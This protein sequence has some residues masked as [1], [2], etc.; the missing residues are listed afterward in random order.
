MGRAALAPWLLGCGLRGAP[1]AQVARRVSGR[2]VVVTGASRGIGHEV[3]LRLAGVGAHVVALG[4]SEGD[5]LELQTACGR[6]AGSCDR[7]AFD[8][9]DDLAAGEAAV[10][11]LDRWGPPELIVANAGHSI[12]RSVAQTAGRWHDVDRLARLHYLGTLALM[13]PLLEGMMAA[14]SG[15]LL[16]VSSVSVDWPL[17]NWSTYTGSKAGLEAWLASAGPELAAA[18]VAVTSVHL[19]RVATAMSAPTAGLYHTPELSVRQA[20][21]VVCRALVRRPRLVSPWWARVGA[22]LNGAGLG[23]THAAWTRLLRAGVSP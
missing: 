22:A 19:P 16:H 21:D 18:G 6:L 14:G 20:A 7:L 23:A 15:H 12:H 13:L 3:A 10:T 9:R 1:P 8:L 5:L 4:R 2:T 17:P 11:V